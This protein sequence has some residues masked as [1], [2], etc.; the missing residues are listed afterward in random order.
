MYILR[1]QVDC[2]Y[3]IFRCQVRVSVAIL[4]QVH[5][6]TDRGCSIVLHCNA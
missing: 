2:S 6:W 5:L 3:R 4:A 1:S